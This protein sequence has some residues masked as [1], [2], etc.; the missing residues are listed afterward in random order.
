MDWDSAT[1]LSKAKLYGERAHEQPINSA[2]FGFWMSLCLELLSRAALAK[3]HP[4]LLADPRDEGN[5]QYSFGIIPKSNPRSIQ[6]KTVFARCSI[7]I[8]GFTDQMSAHCLIIADRRNK[9]L[10]TG[11]AEFEGIDNSTWLPQTYEVFEVLLK[12]LE[13]DFASFFGDDQAKVALA[14]LKDRRQ[15]IKSEVQKKVAEARRKFEA[16]NGEE[17]ATRAA[18]GQELVTA[19]VKRSALRQICKCPSCGF[20]A[21]LSGESQS[22]GP[23]RV[24]EDKGIITRE[25]RV[26]PNALHCPTCLLELSGYQ[27][28]LQAQLGKV[29]VTSE[30]EDPIEFFGIIPEEHVDI[31]LLMRQ[32]HEG[33]Y[34]NE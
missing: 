28:L 3:I 24:D 30:E 17:K 2:L 22:R 11:S 12:H 14:M 13:I 29:F 16:L 10:H 32:Y 27:E 31:D 21:A 33:E 25:V 6:A 9:E 26:L 23:V 5:I 18:K 34:D 19:W 15:H 8:A 4:V 1:L 20:N 7:F